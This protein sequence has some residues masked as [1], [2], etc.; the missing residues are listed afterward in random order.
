M[1]AS[2]IDPA[3]VTRLALQKAA[4]I[5]GLMLTTEALVADIRKTRRRA[6]A[7]AVVCQ[8]VAAEWAACTKPSSLSFRASPPASWRT[9]RN[10]LLSTLRALRFFGAPFLFWM[11]KSRGSRTGEYFANLCA[12]LVLQM[13]HGAFT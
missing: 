9:T 11:H 7:R 6:Q 10:L 3:K 2:V 13:L 8:A 4:S 5:A 12:F 1:K